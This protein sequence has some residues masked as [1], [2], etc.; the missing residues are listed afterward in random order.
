MDQVD[1]RE[2]LESLVDLSNPTF[3]EISRRRSEGNLVEALQD[4][5]QEGD[6]EEKSYHQNRFLNHL[7]RETVSWQ[8]PPGSGTFGEIITRWVAE[9]L[10]VDFPTL[11]TSQA[12]DKY[13]DI[14][15]THTDGGKKDIRVNLDFDIGEE[16]L[17]HAE[18]HFMVS[19][20]ELTERR[21]RLLEEVKQ[22]KK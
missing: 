16:N 10:L 9:N 15:I 8:R 5:I 6:E 11:K 2:T 12:E 14:K 20:K 7:R 17:Y 18:Y 4:L 3:R 21:A 22:L 19:E 13:Q 1:D